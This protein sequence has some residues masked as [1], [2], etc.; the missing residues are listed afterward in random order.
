MK[1]KSPY[2]NGGMFEG[3]SH[4]V[5]GFAKELRKDMTDSEKVLWMHLKSGI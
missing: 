1:Q 5:F 3:A 2:K 4:L